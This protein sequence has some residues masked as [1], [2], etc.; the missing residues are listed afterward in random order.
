MNYVH[1]YSKNKSKKSKK[2][3]DSK[4]KIGKGMCV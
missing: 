2:C 3:Y 1:I 4:S